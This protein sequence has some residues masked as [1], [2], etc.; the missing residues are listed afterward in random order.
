MASK[1][2]EVILK[3]QD[4]VSSVLTGVRKNLS[5]FASSVAQIAAG[6]GAAFGA[7][8][9][10]QFFASSVAAA[11]NADRAFA[12]VGAALRNV[13]VDAKTARPEVDAL[14]QKL[15]L[16]SGVDDEKI[17]DAFARLV[18]ATGDYRTALNL[19]PVALDVSAARQVDLAT[20]VDLTSK[21]ANGN[22]T[23]L[24]RMGIEVQAGADA[25]QVLRDRFGGFAASEGQSM[26]GTLG[27]VSVA[28]EN[29]KEEIGKAIVGGDQFAG[30]GNRIVDTLIRLEAWIHENGSEMRGFAGA[31]V[32]LADGLG[33]I[34][35]IVGP[36]LLG[37]F[38]G[39]QRAIGFFVAGLRLLP[40]DAGIATAALVAVIADGI[41][42]ISDLLAK[43]G[44]TA[45]NAYAHQFATFADAARAKAVQARKDIED[46]LQN[47]LAATNGPGDAAP[48][49]HAAAHD[50]ATASL[51]R[52]TL[53]LIRHANA[54]TA[55]ALELTKLRAREAD[56]QATV[57]DGT[58]S[59]ADRAAASAHL[60]QVHAALAAATDLATESQKK[61]EQALL[62]LAHA[63]LATAAQ[64]DDL[65]RREGVYQAV[66]DSSRASVVQKADALKAL[67]AIQQALG[68]TI[69]NPRG[70]DAYIASLED[71]VKT[72]YASTAQLAEL[73][74]AELSYQA[75]LDGGVHTVDE[76]KA[77]VDRL[78]HAREALG[79]HLP[80]NAPAPPDTSVKLDPSVDIQPT[81]VSV[82]SD[83]T[84]SKL[85]GG[86]SD[87]TRINPA[88]LK[89]STKALTEG[90]QDAQAAVQAFGNTFAQ[91]FQQVLAGN[92]S[93]GAAIA[94]TGRAA[95]GAV[96]AAE[97]QFYYAKAA[98]SLAEG[99][100]GKPSGF[101][102]A[103]KFTLA[104][105]TFQ[106]LSAVLG[107]SGGGGGAAS[108]GG[109]GGGALA[110]GNFTNS[111]NPAAQPTLKIVIAGGSSRDVGLQ[112]W[113]VATLKD[114]QGRGVTVE[115]A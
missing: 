9:L 41:R 7:A 11:A 61:H 4:G 3:A 115:V 12:A 76:M 96:A 64:L 83:A 22:T 89:D 85:H 34:A 70:S 10:G 63:G 101:A 19:L 53:A 74:A 91:T 27:R 102:A 57:D 40:A 17:K 95:I 35:G 100:G 114:A 80:K 30:T 97:A 47:G 1:V 84:G 107:G 109:G 66:L 6:I 46:D 56:L 42:D 81:N 99:I 24:K 108:A 92:K 2:V 78:R 73:Q 71:L 21:A 104:A 33:T 31:V 29:M 38:N 37:A 90:M 59:Q 18:T 55:T 68:Q 103:A 51:D 88:D 94:A 28:W 14:V 98:A 72:G 110:P 75:V 54:G 50:A 60:A 48:G 52:E 16:V 93:L 43:L 20:A 13:G 82:K 8:A 32:D 112:D 62:T 105:A 36:V 39:A 77:A 65:R 58:K 45:G 79:D 87:I 69:I 67:Q 15:S 44:F 25:V 26:S 23:A 5:G 86:L 106:A 49:G 113:L 111:T